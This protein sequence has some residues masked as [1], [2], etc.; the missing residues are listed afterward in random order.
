MDLCDL[1]VP[2][3]A[4]ILSG[5]PFIFLHQRFVDAAP[6]EKEDLGVESHLFQSFLLLQQNHDH[7]SAWVEHRHQSFTPHILARVSMPSSTITSTMPHTTLLHPHKDKTVIGSDNTC[8]RPLRFPPKM[9]NNLAKLWSAG[10]VRVLD[11]ENMSQFGICEI[12]FLLCKKY[13]EIA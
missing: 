8:K 10:K 11:G 9:V 7:L 6:M 3:V 12:R 1:P 13:D 5:H 4:Y 2:H